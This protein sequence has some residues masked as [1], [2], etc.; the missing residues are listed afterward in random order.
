MLT[1]RQN[2]LETIRGG[3]P[4]RFVN[5]FEAIDFIWATPY[6]KHSRGMV[7]PGGE[8]VN[9]WGVT[10]RFQEGTPGPFPVHDDEHIVLK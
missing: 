7:R 6:N 10:I 8:A 1:K 9:A 5:Q 4:D 2:M 3:N